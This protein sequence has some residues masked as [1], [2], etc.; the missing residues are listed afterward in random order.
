MDDAKTQ[1]VRS[2]LIKAG[3]DLL[4]ASLLSAKEKLR[5][6]AIFHCQQAAEKAIKGFLVFHDVRFEKSHDIEFLVSLGMTKV[7]E[8]GQLLPQAECLTP[9]ATE[10][11]YP[12]DIMGPDAHEYERAYQAAIDIC[13]FVV[14]NMPVEVT[15]DLS[16]ILTT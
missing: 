6:A 1:A 13:Q 16:T 12:G 7:A 14:K 11:R 10:F 4:S 8:L 3:H 9:Y 2:W 5:D 15:K